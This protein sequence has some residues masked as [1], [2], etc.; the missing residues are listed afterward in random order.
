MDP[1]LHT[2]SVSFSDQKELFGV[3]ED[4]CT[5]EY[6]T[7]RCCEGMAIKITDSTELC[8]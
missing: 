7:R 1:K 5:G 3:Q 6:S 8:T 4:L 2:C